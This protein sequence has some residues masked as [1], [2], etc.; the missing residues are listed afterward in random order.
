VFDDWNYLK[1]GIHVKPSEHKDALSFEAVTEGI[2]NRLINQASQFLMTWFTNVLK[3]WRED[4]FH[5]FMRVGQYQDI[6]GM[7]KQGFDFVGDML[8]N[9]QREFN[10]LI[11][12]ASGGIDKVSFDFNDMTKRAIVVLRNHGWRQF[13]PH[14]VT[15]LHDTLE[16]IYAII[17]QKRQQKLARKR[18]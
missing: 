17:V 12:V 9:H 10:W 11:G 15:C 8:M 7:R 6:R 3:R 2:N 16:K 14:E 18:F 5:Y 1:Q 4:Q 13:A